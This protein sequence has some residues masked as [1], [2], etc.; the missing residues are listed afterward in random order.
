MCGI[1]PVYLKWKILVSLLFR[2]TSQPQSA[3]SLKDYEVPSAAY[4]EQGIKKKLMKAHG[5]KKH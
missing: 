1:W 5:V 3:L 2:M 4:K